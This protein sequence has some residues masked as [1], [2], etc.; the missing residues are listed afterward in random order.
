MAQRLW[1]I[2]AVFGRRRLDAVSQETAAH[3]LFGSF[4][5]LLRF[6]QNLWF[7]FKSAHSQK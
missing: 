1:F 2:P 3:V 6:A 4:G 7:G 5:F